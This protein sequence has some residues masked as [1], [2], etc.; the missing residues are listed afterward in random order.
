MLG[1]LY[2]VG[3]GVPK[4][5]V[6]AVKW[7]HKA[8]EQGDIFAQGDL[9][10]LYMDGRGVTQNKVKAYAWFSL[11]VNSAVTQ[12]SIHQYK[13]FSRRKLHRLISR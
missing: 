11:A 9:G 6:E 8:A 1:F 12:G 7:Y 5:Y 3:Q 10:S 2:A 4:D 13:S